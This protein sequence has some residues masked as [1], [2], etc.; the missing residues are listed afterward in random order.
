MPKT[1]D[2]NSDQHPSKRR[3]TKHASTDREGSGD[4]FAALLG[5]N[6]VAEHTRSRESAFR[7]CWTET[8]SRVAH[9]L[10]PIDDVSLEEIIQFVK[11]A[12]TLSDHKRLQ[13]G[14]ICCGPK[15]ASQTRLLEKWKTME[16]QKKT[17]VVVAIDAAQATNLMTALK[18]LIRAAITQLAGTDGYQRSL[19]ERRHRICMN[20]DLELLQ[21]F[22]TSREIQKCVI[23]LTDI[24]AFDMVLLADL[25]SVVSAWRDRIPFVL[26]LGI[27]TTVDLFEARLSKSTVRL[28]DCKLFDASVGADPCL[29]MYKSLHDQSDA[30]LPSF[31]PVISGVLFEMSREQDASA[32]GFRRAIKYVMMSHFFAN[33]LSILLGPDDGA[34]D[35]HRDFCDVIRSTGSFRA[36]AEEKLN[37]GDSKTV[38]SLLG[39]DKA[40]LRA[41]REG[42]KNGLEA[43]CRHHTAVELFELT[44]NLI[45]PPEPP[46]DSFSIQ[47]QALSS[48]FLGSALYTN[49]ISNITTLP[50]NRIR[51]LLNTIQQYHSL[52]NLD[53]QNLLK[54]LD[55][56]VPPTTKIPLRSAYDP[57]HTTTSTTITNNKVSLSKHLPK[58]SAPETVYTRL[59]DHIADTLST[60]F[61]QHILNPTTLFL[62]EAFLYDL[63]SPWLRPSRPVHAA[64]SNV[65][66]RRRRTILAVSVVRAGRRARSRPRSR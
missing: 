26:L 24:E 49:L 5:G 59:V 8:S 23:Y 46:L 6:E 47:L 60:H 11:D 12:P 63:K 21:E 43:M 16:P 58:L 20:Y 36:Y 61:E 4:Y 34:R 53:I 33:G 66:F 54:R 62:H 57:T 27:S 35:T 13:T 40:L 10:E 41:A 1:A 32:S 25:M 65:P 37:E 18:N 2:H 48:S 38:R 22:V 7:K 19:N 29:E 28:L 52:P 17:A 44:L 50:S 31:G 64:P 14:L 55:Q 9:L 39:D 30:L 45:N 42:V 51:K 15:S 56:A 3:K